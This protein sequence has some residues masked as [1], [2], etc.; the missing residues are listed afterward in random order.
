MGA[1]PNPGNFHM[2]PIARLHTQGDLRHER[3]HHHQRTCSARIVD[4]L[5]AACQSVGAV[6]LE[7]S[8]AEETTV[9]LAGP[10]AWETVEPGRWESNLL[11]GNLAEMIGLDVL[12]AVLV[13]TVFAPAE[14]IGLSYLAK[15]FGIRG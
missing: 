7:S 14:N 11:R 2:H 1:D 9:A 8:P 13:P 12:H 3:V 6:A 4:C 15:A 5:P 10:R